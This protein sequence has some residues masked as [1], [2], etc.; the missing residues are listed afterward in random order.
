VFEAETQK[1]KSKPSGVNTSTVACFKGLSTHEL[2][3]MRH[4]YGKYI[5]Q[6]KV[7]T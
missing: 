6:E 3:F 5:K 1:E 7:Y 2:S 4:Y